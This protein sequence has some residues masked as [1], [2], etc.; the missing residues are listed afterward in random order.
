MIEYIVIA[1]TV[2]NEFLV[3][4]PYY[5]KSETQIQYNKLAESRTDII[6]ME[7]VKL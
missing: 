3:K 4:G 5:D 6:N 1:Y 2:L 7:I